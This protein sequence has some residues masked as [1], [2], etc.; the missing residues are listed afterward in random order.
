MK[1]RSIRMRTLLLILPLVLLTLIVMSYTSYQYSKEL[2]NR[3][4]QDKMTFSTGQTVES[5]N[6]ILVEHSR[7][8]VLLARTVESTGNSL[9]KEQYMGIFKEIITANEPTLGAGI[10][11]EPF[12]YAPDQKYFGPYVYKD[13]ANMVE[14]L[15]YETAEYDYPNQSWYTMGKGVTSSVVWSDPYYDETTGITM[16]TAA[17][18]YYDAA[19]KFI[20]VTTGDVDLANLQKL[21]NSIKVGQSGKA[22]L[23]GKDGTYIAYN[24]GT[25]KTVRQMKLKISE[26]ENASLKALGAKMAAE[27]NGK[28]EYTENGDKMHAYYTRLNETGWSLAL[29]IPERELYSSLNNLMMRSLIIIAAAVV[30]IILGISYYSSYIRNSVQKVNDFSG[31]IARGDLTQTITTASE[32]EIGQMIVNLNDMVGSMRQVITDVVSNITNLVHTSNSLAESADQTQKANEQIADTM[33]TLAQ[34]RSDEQKIFVKAYDTTHLISSGMKE[35]AGSVQSVSASSERTAEESVVG[36]KVVNDS[37]TQMKEINSQVKTAS[38]VVN[39]LG[40]KSKE[41]DQIVALITSISEQTNLL[42][43]NAAIEAA[44]AGEHGRGFAVVAEEVRK[45]AEQSGKAADNIGQLIKLIQLEIS[46]AVESMAVGTR[47][48]EEGIVLIERAGNSFNTIS[49]AVA[50]VSRQVRGVAETVE[51]IYNNTSYLS[52]SMDTLSHLSS[53][54]MEGIEGIAAAVEEQ[55]ALAKEVSHAAGALSDMSGDLEADVRRFTL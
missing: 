18:P 8:P 10:W 32:D 1:I 2:I 11:Y 55:A 24:D 47:S 51:T 12:A 27:G 30:I 15:D 45:L 5:I 6:R 37:I 16:I 22:F 44:R 53:K 17:A 21:V 28:G 26:D 13:G 34:K 49:E 4:I 41:I 23:I 20:G 40:E 46:N 9:T 35:I 36:N 33:Q 38:A 3:E 54:S 14:T 48:A 50:D 25:S 29:A 42:A 39:L 43:L 31:V 7:I 19:G 52:D